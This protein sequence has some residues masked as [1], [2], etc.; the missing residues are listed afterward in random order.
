MCSTIIL[1]FFVFNSITYKYF[2]TVAAYINLLSLSGNRP[3]MIHN[4]KTYL[5]SDGNRWLA[6]RHHGIDRMVLNVKMFCVLM[7]H[8]WFTMVLHEFGKPCPVI[9]HFTRQ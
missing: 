2:I 6:N 5:E 9:V 7:L 3:C 1:Q 4:N 8:G